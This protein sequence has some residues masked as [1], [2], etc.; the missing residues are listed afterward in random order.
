[1]E[2]LTKYHIKCAARAALAEKGGDHV[3]AARLRSQMKLRLVLMSETEGELEDLAKA[4]DKPVEDLRQTV[5]ECKRTAFEWLH[6][7][8]IGNSDFKTISK[9]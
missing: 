8:T 9:N 4:L 3:T 6:D 7:L 5:K 2:E 1:M